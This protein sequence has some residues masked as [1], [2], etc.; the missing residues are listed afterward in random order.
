MSVLRGAIKRFGEDV[1]ISGFDS[2]IIIGNRSDYFETKFLIES[3]RL[4]IIYLYM[5]KD[6]GDVFSLL[7]VFDY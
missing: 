6:I 5:K 2:L 3:Y 7:T 4:F 1:T